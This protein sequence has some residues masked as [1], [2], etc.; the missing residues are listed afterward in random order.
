MCGIAGIAAFGRSAAPTM[1]QLR[2]MCATI[3]HR[4]PDEEGLDLRDGVALGMRRLSIID[5][6]GGSQPIFNED[7]TVRVVFNGEIYNFR[8][9]RKDLESRGHEFRTRTD[10]EVIVHAYETYGADFPRH[11]NGMFAFALH[12]MKRRKLILARDHTGIKPLY[13]AFTPERIVWGS[14][15]KAVLASGQV[16]RELDVDA[17]AQ[18]LSWE[19]VPGSRTLLKAV[20]KLEPAHMIEFDLDRPSCTPRAYWDVPAAGRE[21]GSY[22]EWVEAVDAKVKQAVQRQLVSDVPLGAFLSGGVD[23]S[24]VVSG[25]GP[26]S[27]FS[28]GFDD[29]SYSELPWSSKVARHLGVQH[30]TEIIRPDAAEL[31]PKLMHFLDDPIGD[32][33]IFPTFLVSRLARKHVT[34]SLSGDG[35]DELFGGYETYLA[36]RLM[37][38]FDFLPRALRRAANVPFDRLLA[39]SPRKKGPVNKVKRLM[40]GF[41]HPAALRHARWRLFMDERG[42]DRLFTPDARRSVTTPVGQHI[43][44]LF[45]RAEGHDAINRGLY[46]DLKSYLCDNIFTKVDRMS[47]A[48]SLEARVP[49]LDVELVELAFEIPGRLKVRGGETKAL[50]KSVAAKHVPRECVYRPKEGFS[51]PIKNWLCKELRPLMDDLLD[52]R[53]VEGRGLFNAGEVERLKQEHL[54]NRANHSHLLWALMVFEHWQRTWMEKA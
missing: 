15:I 53:V 13:Y 50:L 46:V 35:G 52:R 27:T 45:R 40:E 37:S 41:Q 39:P 14:E 5:L 36:Q 44:E 24:L 8:E 31:F 34:V 12:D 17:L 42:R 22:A 49:Y 23:S 20:N 16:P 32:F 18:F 43:G 51:I 33:S 48:V 2:A 19:Y 1:E 21:I 38:K 7:R 4:G 10:T 29:P 3:V 47:M 26:A 6:A 30:T 54:A 25:M 9:L 11:L 28:I